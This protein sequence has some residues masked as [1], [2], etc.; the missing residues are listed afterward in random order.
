MPLFFVVGFFFFQ[1]GCVSEGGGE[2]VS[3]FS[4]LV[5]LK[6]RREKREAAKREAAKREAAKREAEK[7]Q[8]TLPLSPVRVVD[9]PTLGPV[10]DAGHQGPEPAPVERGVG[11]EQ[12]VCCVR[13]DKGE[14]REERVGREKKV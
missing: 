5:F 7:K 3:L 9:G 13:E 14:R 8:K 11:L 6:N 2:K 10:L 12:P 4:H 1:R